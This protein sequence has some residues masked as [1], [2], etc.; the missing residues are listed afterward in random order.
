MRY[1]V[2][3]TFEKLDIVLDILQ[4]KLLFCF[5]EQTKLRLYFV[6]TNNLNVDLNNFLFCCLQSVI[7]LVSLAIQN[8]LGQ[9]KVMAE[10]LYLIASLLN[11]FIVSDDIII[12]FFHLSDKFVTLV[13]INILQLTNFCK[14]IMCMLF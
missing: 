2:V 7:D 5:L 8:F 1:H 10:T 12:Q 3:G 14:H 13:A 11:C 4:L 9:F 6:Q